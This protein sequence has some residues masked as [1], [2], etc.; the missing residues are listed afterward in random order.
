MKRLPKDLSFFHSHYADD[1][2]ELD[3]PT[4]LS[5]SV[6]PITSQYAFAATL[7]VHPI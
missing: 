3:G 1:G 5:L 2:S 6:D 7:S 4:L